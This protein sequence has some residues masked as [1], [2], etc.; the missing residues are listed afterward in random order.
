MFDHFSRTTCNIGKRKRHYLIRDSSQGNGP[1]AKATDPMQLSGEFKGSLH[2]PILQFLTLFEK[3]GGQTHGKKNA[4][5]W[6][7]GQ[8]N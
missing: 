7:S 5:N 6:T 8:G 1:L 3:K 4:A 2:R